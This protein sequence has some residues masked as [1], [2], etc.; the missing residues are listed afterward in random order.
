MKNSLSQF[1]RLLFAVL[2]P[3]LLL[4]L[5]APA[6]AVAEASPLDLVRGTAKQVFDA[7]DSERTAYR[8][9]PERLYD[10]VQKVVLPHFDFETMGRWVLGKNWRQATPEQQQRFVKEFT[11]LL[12]RSYA[13]SLLEYD[14]EQLS[15]QPFQAPA[16]AKDVTVRS[17][18]ALAGAPPV[19][20]NYSMHR[21]NGEWKVYDVSIDGISLVTNYRSTFAQEMRQGGI[22]GL[23]HR[24]AE[25]NAKME[26]EPVSGRTVSG[27]S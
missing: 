27:A 1:Y 20:I 26:A 24:L 18:V 23:I 9:H 4:G 22:D 17:Q 5:A 2:L 16:D 12:V 14:D 10:L 7:I 15:Y 11:Q 19:P 25:R 3:A 13:T 21:V 8:E 6:R